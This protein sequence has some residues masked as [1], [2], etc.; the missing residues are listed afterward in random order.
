MISVLGILAG[1]HFY[2]KDRDKKLLT[3]KR[4]KEL[5]FNIDVHQIRWFEIKSSKETLRFMKPGSEKQWKLKQN[6]NWNLNQGKV[7]QLIRFIQNLRFQERLHGVEVKK[8]FGLESGKQIQIASSQGVKKLLVGSKVPMKNSFYVLLDG[9]L[10][11]LSD[12]IDSTFYVQASYYRAL[13][14][15]DMEGLQKIILSKGK[16]KIYEVIRVDKQIFLSYPVKEKISDTFFRDLKKTKASNVL[17]G[18]HV[19]SRYY[20]LQMMGEQKKFF[21]LDRK[22]L[23]DREKN[24]TYVFNQSPVSHSSL[25]IRSKRLFSDCQK[26]VRFR[27]H[28]QVDFLQLGKL[29]KHAK[30]M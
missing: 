30:K 6:L 20:E 5:L 22:K 14:P 13:M 16:K 12:R 11:L 24:E 28:E 27:L 3:Q 8:S 26:L 4:E 2:L 23:W 15:F 29:W 10:G 25:E 1:L 21:Y 17:S 7:E 19:S 9:Q 18:R